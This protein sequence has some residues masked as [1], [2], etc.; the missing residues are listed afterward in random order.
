MTYYFSVH[1]NG[2][3]DCDR[4]PFDDYSSALEACTAYVK[5]RYAGRR[6]I[7]FQSELVNGQFARSYASLDLPEAVDRDGPMGA[8][9][10]SSAAKFSNAFIYDASYVFMI[11]SEFGLADTAAMQKLDEDEDD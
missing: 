9:R 8:A 2:M 11:E 1:K 5:P 3:L 6:V 4:Q 7:T 10:Y